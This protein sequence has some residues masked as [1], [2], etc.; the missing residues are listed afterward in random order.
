MCGTSTFLKFDYTQENYVIEMGNYY[1]QIS[2]KRI[3]NKKLKELKN[4]IIPNPTYTNI[5]KTYK[6]E[7]GFV[8]QAFLLCGWVY[9]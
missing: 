5:M 1:E 4:E 3:K 9:N 7:S 2:H 8:K 6:A